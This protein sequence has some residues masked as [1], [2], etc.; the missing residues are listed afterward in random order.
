MDKV[1]IKTGCIIALAVAALMMAADV[2]AETYDP[3][4]TIVVVCK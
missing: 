3:R 2:D 1:I 4:N